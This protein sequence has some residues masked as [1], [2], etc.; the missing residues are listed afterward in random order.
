VH[1]KTTLDRETDARFWAQT[2][3]KPGRRLDPSDPTD[4]HMVKVWLDVRRKVEAEDAAGALRITYDHPE[5]QGGI[6]DAEVASAA[7]AAHLEAAASSDPAAEDHARAATDATRA[8]AAGAAR[9]AAAQPATV[10]PHVAEDAAAGV[11]SEIGLPPPE[12]IT[13]SLPVDHPVWTSP[14][15]APSPVPTSIQVTVLAGDRVQVDGTDTDLYTLSQRA[16]AV[17]RAFLDI[18][19]EA[20]EA[21]AMRVVEQLKATGVDVQFGKFDA[22]GHGEAGHGMA[23][24]APTRPRSATVPDQFAAAQAIASPRVAIA[25]HEEERARPG[26]RSGTEVPKTIDQIRRN[27]RAIA[28]GV[29][30]QHLGV[31]LGASGWDGVKFRSVDEAADWYGALTDHPEGF[32]Y[33]AR[34]DRTSPAWPGPVDELF[35]SGKVIR[36]SEHAPGPGPA[37]EYTPELAPEPMRP[38]SEKPWPKVAI[39]VG[40][41]AAIGAVIAIASNA[42]RRQ[43]S[44]RVT[45][46]NPRPPSGTP[47]FVLASAGTGRG[48]RR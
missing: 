37:T 7:A 27:A 17:Q 46:V 20:R 44:T 19:P 18:R 14:S 35:G 38:A 34:F 24:G 1:A 16:H 6:S 13:P 45:F 4:R 29:G 30:T 42:S 28:E 33:I 36:V 48:G 2:G 43:P 23:N 12:P 25:A 31:L 9:A 3:Y 21:W 39:V 15:A 40:G 22:E 26:G 32:R 10:S 8:A 47:R 5:V 11:A 41:L